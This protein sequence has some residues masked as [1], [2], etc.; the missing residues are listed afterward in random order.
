MAT[1]KDG[2]IALNTFYSISHAARELNLHKGHISKICRGQRK[3]TGGFS[4]KYSNNSLRK[5]G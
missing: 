3:S 2:N 5:V 4:W 1:S